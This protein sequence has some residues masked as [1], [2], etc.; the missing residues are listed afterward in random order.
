VNHVFERQV[1]HPAVGWGAVPR[2]DSTILKRE[3]PLKITF[4]DSKAAPKYKHVTAFLKDRLP[5]L[6]R[7]GHVLKAFFDST[8]TAADQLEKALAWPLPPLLQVMPLGETDPIVAYVSNDKLILDQE[9]ADLYEASEEKGVCSCQVTSR[10]ENWAMVEIE[11]VRGLGVWG[12]AKAGVNRDDWDTRAA[13][14][15]EAVFGADRK[16]TNKR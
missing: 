15:V 14:F 10:G 11:I 6:K 8:G 12:C 1:N 4:S 3:T 2:S 9:M 5:K 16:A 13:Q 7:D